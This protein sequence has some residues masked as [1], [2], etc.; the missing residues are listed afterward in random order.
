M[1]SSVVVKVL[2]KCFFT[3]MIINLRRFSYDIEC[4]VW[5]NFFLVKTL[6]VFF[7]DI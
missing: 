1:I 3:K 4:E 6:K 2:M 7:F 5:I